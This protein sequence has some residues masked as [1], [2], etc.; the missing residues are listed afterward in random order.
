DNMSDDEHR[1]VLAP[2]VEEG[3]VVFHDWPVFP[4]QLQAYER[5]IQ[6]HRDDS[7]WIAFLDCDEFLFSPTRRKVSEILP[8]FEEFPGVGVNCLAYGNSGHE[9]RPD[10]LTIE[11][12]VCRTTNEFRNRI[13][14]SIV[15]P[16][17][18]ERPGT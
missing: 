10:G 5:C 17:R 8:E 13:I 3:T 12:Y 2:Y 15:D 18:V 16:T 4:G 7:R 6:E 9:T 11:S 1:E 14:K